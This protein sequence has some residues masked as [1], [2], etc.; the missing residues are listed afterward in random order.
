MP[1]W[2]SVS[3]VSKP[4]QQL[5]RSSTCSPNVPKL[6]SSWSTLASKLVTTSLDL[7]WIA[8]FFPSSCLHSEALTSMGSGVKAT[9]MRIE[10]TDYFAA[11]P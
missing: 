11:T 10:S 3:S 8:P 6:D 4:S 5:S 7:L 9:S 1:L 2:M